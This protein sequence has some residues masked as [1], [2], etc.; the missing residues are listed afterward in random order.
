M[1]GSGLDVIY[2]GENRRLAEDIC[3][4]GTLISEFP[5]GTQPDRGNFP[6]RNRIISGLSHA[7]VIAE[8]GNRSGAILTALNAVDQNRDVFAVPGQINDSQSVGANRLIR[9]GATPV[10]SGAEIIRDINPRLFHPLQPVKKS[11]SIELTDQ[12]QLI[13]EVLRQDPVHIDALDQSVDMDI[14]SLLEFL[15]KLELK[16][17]VQQ[18]GG[19][20]FVR[21]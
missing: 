12:E 15:L 1:L 16:N 18:I 10:S 19:K 6:R 9:N 5:L 14:T 20:Q 13:L 8:A 4:K 7:T 11:I 17:A 2:P 3:Q 21:A